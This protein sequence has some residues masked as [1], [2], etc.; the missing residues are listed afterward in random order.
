MPRSPSQVLVIPFRRSIDSSLE[1]ADFKRRDTI[2]SDIILAFLIHIILNEAKDLVPA[3]PNEM[4]RCVQHN[5][6]EIC[7]L[8][9]DAVYNKTAPRN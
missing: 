2:N 5:A 8:N 3:S 9:Y 7:Q 1:Y 4:L 6:R